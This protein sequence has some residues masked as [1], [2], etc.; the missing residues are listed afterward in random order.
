MQPVRFTMATAL[1][2]ACLAVV[3]AIAGAEAPPVAHWPLEADTRD[4]GPHEL[5]TNS[6][7]VTFEQPG[8]GRSAPGSARFA[9][10]GAHL[11]VD[12]TA[13]P[14]FRSGDFSVALWIHTENTAG[15]ESGDLVSHYDPARRTGWQLGLRTNTGV[16]TSQ[17]NLR[18]LQFGIDAGSELQWRDE[19]R[20][21]GAILAFALAVH[22][23]QLYAGTCEPGSDQAGHVYR[24]ESPGRWTDLGSPDRCNAISAMAQ[25][26]G[27][28]YAGS[29]QYRLAGSALPE[30]DN[31][32]PG[33]RIFRLEADG[34]WGEVGRLADDQTAVGGMVV[35]RGKLY[36]SSLYRPAGFYRYERDGQWTSLPTPDGLRVESLGVFDGFLW[37]TSYDGGYVFRFDGENWKSYGQV[38]DNTQTYSFAVHRGQLCVGTWPSGRVFRLA[39]DDTW[40]DIGRL[41]EEKEVMGMIVHN[42]QL[43]AGTLPLAEV[44]RYEGDQR[45][46]LSGRLDLTPDVT[47]RRAWTMA[48]FQGRLFVS[49]LPS[50]RIHSLEA[51]KC[52]TYDRPLEPGW[53]HIAAVREHERLR[54]F[55]DGRQVAVSTPFD[56]QAFDL[57]TDPASQRPATVID[58]PLV[59]GAGAGDYFRGRMRDVRVY[60]R[61]LSA[62][63]IQAIAKPR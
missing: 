7:G 62:G 40:Q 27:R 44:Y 61:T 13:L 57:S 41:G 30:S 22:D 29:A 37:G 8:G 39:G 42:G 49:T 56:P 28:L 60:A 17:P 26:Q 5:P 15:D 2:A 47:Y 51:G 10:K 3:P 59:I 31:P 55:V 48:Q 4:I 1:A 34:R 20:P 53:R 38:G 50:G 36:A 24:Y 11:E 32:H 16:T 14:A 54:L 19:G 58:P 6:F 12:T 9:A 63:E 23:G 46:S 25:Y 21:G 45:W 52:V 35:Y 43:Y 18:Q 33:G